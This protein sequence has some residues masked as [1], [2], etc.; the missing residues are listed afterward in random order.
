MQLKPPSEILDFTQKIVLVTG[1]SIGIGAGIAKRF[2]QAGAD[3][4]ITY[5]SH[6]KE[7]EL[8]AEIIKSMGRKAMP[9]QTDV[10][11]PEQIKSL[12]EQILSQW[13]P[14]DVLINNAG[15][16]PHSDLLHMR[17]EEWDEMIDINL[18]SIFLCTQA[19]A[20]QMVAAGK[21]GAI[22]NIGSIEGINPAAGHSHYTASKAGVAMFGMTAALELG[23]HNIRVNTVS[24]GLINSPVLPTD[25]PEGVARFLNRVPLGRVGEPED[26]ADACLFFASDASR[27]ITGTQLLV[28]GGVFTCQIY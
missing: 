19:A 26:I 25:W 14:V 4:V 13:G 12:F 5:R 11:N 6:P 2:A 20:Q 1:G 27:W 16:Y 23:P 7:A 3:V 22:V 9:I 24:P 8:I 21:G 17:L 10:A 15:I 28:D 18:R